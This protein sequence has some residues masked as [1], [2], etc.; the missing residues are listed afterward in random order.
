MNGKYQEMLGMKFKQ[1]EIVLVPFPYSNLS[2]IKNRPVLILSNDNFNYSHNDLLVAVITSKM[3]I[4]DYSVE[5][6]NNSLEYGILPEKSVIKT[7]KLFTVSKDIIIK[8]FSI[9]KDEKFDEV[10][11]KISDL[12]NKRK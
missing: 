1:K 3:Y 2:S 6:D 11:K 5:I 10:I 8:K 7:S 12:L 4:D 9:L